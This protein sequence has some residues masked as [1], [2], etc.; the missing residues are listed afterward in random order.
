MNSYKVMTPTLFWDV[1]HGLLLMFSLMK[2]S[3][4]VIALTLRKHRHSK[5]GGHVFVCYK[6]T[7]SCQE[8]HS[9]NKCEA[10]VCQIT[11]RDNKN[12]IVCSFY[13]PPNHD[14]QYATNLCNLF[15]GLCT[16][17]SSS[18]I[19][20]AGDLNLPNGDWK[21]CHLSS[22]TLPSSYVIFL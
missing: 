12:L 16:T 3:H 18:P 1:K 15:R 7:I 20:L 17:Y 5:Q 11:L 4:Q 2:Y 6:D 22:S 14:I 10:V 13:R 8:L 21:Y 19:W 9:N